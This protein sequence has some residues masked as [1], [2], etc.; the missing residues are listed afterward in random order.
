MSFLFDWIHFHSLYLETIAV[1]RYPFLRLY[2]F[3]PLQSIKILP[4]HAKPSVETLATLANGAVE[5]WAFRVKNILYYFSK[6]GN[7]DTPNNYVCLYYFMFFSY[8]YINYRDITFISICFALAVLIR[9][10]SSNTAPAEEG[11]IR[12]FLSSFSLL[13]G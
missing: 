10:Y 2:K 4:Y 7:L 6:I 11:F 12:N 9:H 8:S 13:L 1:S 3:L 5:R